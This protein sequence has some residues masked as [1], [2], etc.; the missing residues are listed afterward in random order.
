MKLNKIFA[1][2]LAA[3][4]LSACS[5]D[6]DK[7]TWNNNSNVTVDMQK[8]EISVKEN[9]GLFNVPVVV[10]GDADGNIMVTVQINET[11]STPA[12]DDSNFLVTS[13]TIVIEPEDKVGNIEIMTVDDAII[14]DPRTFTVTIVEAKGAKIG[15]TPTTT[16][17]LKDNDAAFYEKLQGNWK[18]NFKTSAGADSNWSVSVLGFDEDEPGY[19]EDL[20]VYGLFGYNWTE[21]YMQYHFDTSTLTGGLIIPMGETIAEEVGAGLDDTVSLVLANKTASGL[22]LRGQLD[23]SWSDDFNTITF[24]GLDNMYILGFY[25]TSGDFTGYSFGS[26][27]APMT[28]TR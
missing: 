11:G 28:M 6:D 10:N 5:D 13:K 1:I 18:F 16:V 20:Y 19:N 17:T 9:R 15:N 4:T 12:T 2:A 21:T 8:T 22:T 3:I 14:N 24:S 26:C 25:T 7:A 27:F 23:G